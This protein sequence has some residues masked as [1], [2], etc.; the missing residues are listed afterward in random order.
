MTAPLLK[1]GHR[2]GVAMRV[3]PYGTFQGQTVLLVS[4]ALLMH[5]LRFRRLATSLPIRADAVGATCG[6]EGASW[7]GRDEPRN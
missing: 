5:V 4:H 3:L 2:A 6:R 7:G 1:V